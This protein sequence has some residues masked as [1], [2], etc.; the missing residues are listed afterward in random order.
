MSLSTALNIAFSAP[1]QWHGVGALRRS[2]VDP[3][4]ANSDPCRN[5]GVA[6]F[7]GAE[8]DFPHLVIAGR[9]LNRG[10]RE[11]GLD[12]FQLARVVAVLESRELEP[13]R[14][15]D[16]HNPLCL[17][18]LTREHPFPECSK[19]DTCVRAVVQSGQIC[20]RGGFRERTFR[21]LFHAS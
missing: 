21:S 16:H 13:M 1:T 8:Q 2:V 19:G 4:E 20:L 3:L 15:R 10:I 18:H 14:S 5:V 9:Y 7:E 17:F 12:P 11:T 6:R